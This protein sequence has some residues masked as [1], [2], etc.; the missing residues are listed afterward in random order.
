M[1]KTGKL[2]ALGS[3]I[4]LGVVALSGSAPTLAKDDDGKRF[5]KGQKNCRHMERQSRGQRGQRGFMQRFA[6]VDKNSDERIGADEAAAWRESVFVA[7]DADDDNE[8]TEEEYMA[9]RM[10]H[11]KRGNAER[12]KMKQSQK[13]AR[14]APMDEDKSGTVSKVEWMA[15]GQ[16]AFEAADAD[17]D[18]IVTPWEFRAHR[19]NH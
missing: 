9:V 14:F 3:A 18:G 17:K 10:G 16:A 12:Q 4:A 7:M 13:Q 6:I 19:Q 5:Y 8:L 11:G 2:L 1:L 15:T